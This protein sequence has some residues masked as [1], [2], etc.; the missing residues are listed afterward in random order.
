MFDKFCLMVANVQKQLSAPSLEIN[1]AEV[2]I[3]KFLYNK[4]N[5]VCVFNQKI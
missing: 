1:F 5:K 2:F 3:I 4:E